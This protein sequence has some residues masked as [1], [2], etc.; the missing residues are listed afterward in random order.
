MD[1]VAS[2]NDLDSIKLNY[3]VEDLIK[4]KGK[5]IVYVGDSLPSDV[6][7]AVN[8]LNEVL[9]NSALY[10]YESANVNT[11][12]QLHFPQIQELITSFT[13]GEVGAVIHYDV[14]PSFHLPKSL[15]YDEA[16]ENGD[17]ATV[18][19][20]KEMMTTQLIKPFI[21][22]ENMGLDALEQHLKESASLIAQSKKENFDRDK[23]IADIMDKAKYMKDAFE[24][25]NNFSDIMIDL[26]NKE[27][28]DNMKRDFLNSLSS[29][30]VANKAQERYYQKQ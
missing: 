26:K 22:N 7:I 9:G 10:N 27:A 19:D 25:Y 14:N 20:I 15:K 11:G 4:N 23:Y 30:Y 8:L 5:S 21:F 1:K 24:T 6:H 2:K 12:K 3:L 18:R 17:E 13:N 16:V 29:K 28:T